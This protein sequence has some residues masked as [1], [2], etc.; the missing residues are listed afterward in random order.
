MTISQTYSQ[1]QKMD[2]IEISYNDDSVESNPKDSLS[3]LIDTVERKIKE[4]K[5]L[6]NIRHKR[7]FLSSLKELQSVVGMDKL[8]HGIVLQIKYLIKCKDSKE[9]KK[10]LNTLIYGPPGT[11]KTSVGKILSKLWYSIGYLP[12][13]DK[14]KIS[15]A[16]RDYNLNPNPNPTLLANS[17]VYS[18]ILFLGI[19]LFNTILGYFNG[20]GRVLFILAIIVMLVLYLRYPVKDKR[21][22]PMEARKERIVKDMRESNGLKEELKELNFAPIKIVTR[23]DLVAGYVGQT[24]LKTMKVLEENRGKVLFV[25]EAY[26][27]CRDERDTFGLECLDTIN[28]FLSENPDYIVIFAGYK[29]LIESTIFKY[30]PG[31]RRRFMWVFECV[32]YTPDELLEIFARQIGRDGW[33]LEDRGEIRNLFHTN[34]TDF[35]NYGGDTERLLNFSKINNTNTNFWKKRFDKT[36]NKED[37]LTGLKMLKENTVEC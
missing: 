8:K 7:L 19:I 25:D 12:E 26:S 31:F 18:I 37:V 21:A 3:E 22:N 29:R 9:N 23:D 15:L 34:I 33:E 14:E 27:L 10:M 16:T 6:E 30:Q 13:I 5:G 35:P 1:F 28:K 32:A 11:G 2:S 24:A 20:F 36:L 4:G 17:A